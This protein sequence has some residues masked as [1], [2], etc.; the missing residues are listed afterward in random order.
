MTTLEQV[1]E[2]AKTLPP[3]DRQRL[4]LFLQEQAACDATAAQADSAAQAKAER[5]R[6]ELDEYRR[7]KAW[8]AAHRAEYL[9]QWVVLAGDRLISHGFDGHQVCDE[10]RTAGI[11]VPFLVW[12]HEE[13]AAFMT[14]LL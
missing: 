7:A 6:Q 11:K 13:P 10:A 8:I 2:S 14:G 12:L 3:A 4:Q 1:I 5:L 9:G